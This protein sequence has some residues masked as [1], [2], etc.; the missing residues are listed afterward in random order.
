MKLHPVDQR[1]SPP[2]YPLP[3]FN[4]PLDTR[5]SILSWPASV[6]FQLQTKLAFTVYV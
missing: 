4:F 3:I 6:N 1:H 2:L 5:K